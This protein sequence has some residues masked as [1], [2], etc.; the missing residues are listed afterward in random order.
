M[1]DGERPGRKGTRFGGR[2]Q[3]VSEATIRTPRQIAP[4]RFAQQSASPG[5]GYASVAILLAQEAAA[6]QTTKCKE[7]LPSLQLRTEREKYVEEIKGL[8]AEEGIYSDDPLPADH[9]A[10]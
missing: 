8:C 3:S 10:A 1:G 5:L 7:F 2:P 6:N 9:S 4:L